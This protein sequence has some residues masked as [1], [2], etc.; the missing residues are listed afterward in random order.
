MDVGLWSILSIWYTVLGRKQLR[1][2]PISGPEKCKDSFKEK[3]L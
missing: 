2:E 3:L 1:A